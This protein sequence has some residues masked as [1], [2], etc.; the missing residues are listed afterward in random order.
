VVEHLLRV[1]HWR[2]RYSSGGHGYKRRG[3]EVIL[4]D[5]GDFLSRL[6]IILF[7]LV[8]LIDLL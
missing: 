5:L 6:F 7:I 2:R 8:A 3:I 4:E 1:E